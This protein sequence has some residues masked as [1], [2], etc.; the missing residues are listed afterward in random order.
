MRDPKNRMYLS[1]KTST[2]HAPVLLPPEWEEEHYHNYV[3]KSDSMDQRK[4]D[5]IDTWLNG[6]RWT[7]DIVKELIL[8]FRE[9]GLENETLFLM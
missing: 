6:V 5:P 2:T 1:W 9:R 3:E 7:D 4:Y 8:G